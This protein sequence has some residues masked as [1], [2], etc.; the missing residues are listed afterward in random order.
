MSERTLMLKLANI[1]A[2][3]ERIKND[4]MLEMESL[5]SNLLKWFIG[6]GF[7]ITSTGQLSNL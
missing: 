1:E 3:S 5:R 4:L 2:E 6:A 7:V